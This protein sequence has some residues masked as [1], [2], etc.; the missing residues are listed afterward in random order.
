MTE[1]QPVDV[2]VLDLGLPDG[3]G[4]EWLRAQPHF[5]D[6]GVIV[7]TA[8]GAPSERIAGVRAGADAYLVKPVLMEELA[9]LVGNLMRRLAAVAPRVWQISALDWQI[10]SPDGRQ[11]KLTNTEYRLLSALARTPGQPLDRD[12]IALA[13]GHDP[14]HYDQRRL[15]I[16][17]RR[18]RNKAIEALGQPLPL[19]T[20]HR[21]GYAFTAPIRLA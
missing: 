17:V 13:L 9:T 5:K 18:L 11:V 3:D 14:R 15:E 20:V 12:A 16:T 7:L 8:R 19:E 1:T 21:Q 6:K 10:T 4:L 2:L